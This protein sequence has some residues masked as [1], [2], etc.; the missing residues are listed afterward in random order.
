MCSSDLMAISGLCALA[1]EVVWFRV[2][3]L[4]LDG[5]SYAFSLMLA[6]FLV[7]LALGS[8]VSR[9]IPQARWNWVAALG[10]I[11]FGV[12]LSALAGPYLLSLLPDTYAAVQSGVPW[13]QAHPDTSTALLLALA[14]APLTLLLGVSF[15]V[16]TQAITQGSREPMKLLGWM[17]AA[18]TTGALAGSLLAGFA[19]ILAAVNEERR[20]RA[21]GVELGP[22]MVDVTP[23]YGAVQQHSEVVDHDPEDAKQAEKPVE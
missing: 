19:A 20:R 18:N 8:A 11:E 9:L 14:L 12:A 3:D 1:Y 13:L 23:E 16:A 15:P 10:V 5:T 4:F 7:G 21:E 2:M 6:V 22:P 17:S